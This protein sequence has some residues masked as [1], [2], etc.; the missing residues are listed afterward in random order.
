ME[1]KWEGD[2]IR[3]LNNN[4]K[5]ISEWAATKTSSNKTRCQINSINNSQ[6]TRTNPDFK[7][8]ASLSKITKI[9]I[10]HGDFEGDDN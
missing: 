4:N 8:K 5:T 1:C 3:G 6:D 2:T 10:K 7:A 9:A